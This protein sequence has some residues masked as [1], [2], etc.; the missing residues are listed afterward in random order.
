VQAVQLRGIPQ[1]PLDALAPLRAFLGR[2]AGAQAPVQHLAS[3]DAELPGQAVRIAVEQQVAPGLAVQR[4]IRVGH[5]QLVQ[6]GDV[7]RR[8]RIGGRL[9]LGRDEAAHEL[10]EGGPPGGQGSEHELAHAS[11]NIACWQNFKPCPQCP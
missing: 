5:G 3:E 7:G 10:G 1:Q 9:G 2:S 8:E 11:L 6:P 4:R